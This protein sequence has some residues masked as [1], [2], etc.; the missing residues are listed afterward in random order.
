MK[1]EVSNLDIE[2]QTI[3]GSA[4]W[5]KAMADLSPMNARIFAQMVK[6][7]LTEGALPLKIKHFILFLVFVVKGYEPLARLHAEAAKR[8]GATFEE[9]HEVLFTAI[10]SRGV[11]AYAEGARILGLVHGAPAKS[12]KEKRLLEDRTEKILSYFKRTFG[13]VPSFVKLLADKQPALLQAYYKGRSET[14]K[15]TA[16]PR[17]YKELLLVGLNA[18]ERYPFGMESHANGALASGATNEELLEAMTTSVLGGGI[19]AWIEAAAVYFRVTEK[20]G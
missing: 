13:S 6:A 16:L 20:E 17:K 9:W 12:R 1:M 15:N 2:L 8:A 19:P 14:L 4:G 11:I 10:L 5:L 18:S 7:I 3:Y